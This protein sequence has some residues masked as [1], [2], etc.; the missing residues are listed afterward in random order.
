MKKSPWLTGL[1]VLMLLSSITGKSQSIVVPP[2]LQELIGLSVQN[3]LKLAG[4]QVDKKIA[5]EQK[6]AVKASYLPKLEIGGKYMYAYTSMSSHLDE[7]QGF[8]SLEQLKAM[9]QNPAFPVLFPNLAQ[10]T[11]ELTQLQQMLVQQGITLPGM[12]RDLNASLYGHYF[13]LDATAKVLLYSGGQVPNAVKALGQKVKSEEALEEKCSSDLIAEVI[14]C[15]DQLALIDQSSK[16]LDESTKRLASEKLYAETA[17]ANGMAT[18]FDTLKISV[19]TANLNAKQAELRSKTEMLHAKLAQLTGK[20]AG[21][22]EAIH[23]VLE[24]MLYTDKSPSIDDR[25]ELKALEAGLEAR[26]YMLQSEKSHYLP[27]VQAF[28]S[29]RYDQVLNGHANFDDPVYTRMQTDALALGPTMMAG[30][31]FKWELFDRSGGTSKVNQARLEVKKAELAKQEA[32][33]LLQLNLSKARTSYQS[34]IE[35]VEWK[36]QQLKAAKQ[37][38]ELAETSYREGMINIT[39][40]LAAETELQ[41]STLEYLQSIYAQ[42]QSV[43]EYYKATGDLKLSNIQSK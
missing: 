40:R 1:I 13:G 4:K 32:T 39:E 42:R 8:E 28:A 7:L 19:A 34:S 33:D 22:F 16:A 36:K 17:L 14:S 3:D 5:E 29:A 35:Q 20:S 41:S 23:P 11:N 9:M 15:Y 18:S 43:I 25:A 37:A 31:G 10:L 24:P 12:T 2:E 21:S 27:K 30:V 38:L 26:K 6:K